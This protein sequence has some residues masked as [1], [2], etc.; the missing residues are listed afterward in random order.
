MESG[1]YGLITLHRPSNVDDLDTFSG[2]L[3]TFHDILQYMPLIFPAHP[4]T[5][6]QI[7]K[8]DTHGY[9]QSLEDFH[10]IDPVGYL[11]FIA[12]EKNAGVILTD[13]GGIQEESTVLGIPCLTLRENTERPVTI[14]EGTN[15]LVRPEPHSILNA[16]TPVINERS[17]EGKIPEKWDGQSA[18]R[19]VKVLE[20]IRIRHTERH[21]NPV[22]DI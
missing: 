19:I 4:R 5:Q 3:E 11:E 7:E 10:L 13:S 22:E 6:K 2:I 20:E 9:L 15:Q 18:G 14:T 8:L 21:S 1:K 12:L 17:S 16:I